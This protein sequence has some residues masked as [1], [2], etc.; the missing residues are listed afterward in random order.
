MY[1]I[2]TSPVDFID[3]HLECLMDINFMAV[4]CTDIIF[5][6]CFFRSLFFLGSENSEMLH[7]TFVKSLQ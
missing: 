3:F 4:L 6:Q 5:R 2:H 7:R 1:M